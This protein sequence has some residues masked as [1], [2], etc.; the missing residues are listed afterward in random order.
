MDDILRNILLGIMLAAPIGPAGVAVIQSGL[1]W[2]FGRAFL[3]GLGITTAD[4]TYMLLVYLGLSSFIS[5]PIV[6]IAIWGMG[7]LVLFYLGLQSIRDGGRKINFDS[8]SEATTSAANQ[9]PFLVG[10]LVNIS[11]PIAVVFWLGIFG[12]LISVSVESRPG[13]EALFSGL[14]IL[15]G[16]LAWHTSMSILTH[17]GKRFVNAN[18]ARVIS[19]V[20]GL[21]LIGF[22]LRFAYSAVSTLISL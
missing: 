1:R 21:A 4:L 8:P 16:I 22:G 19:I 17:W 13:L 15:V 12:S 2:G 18:T 10:Y 20:A 14:S 3:T 6:K 9:N 11:N 7:T 5:I